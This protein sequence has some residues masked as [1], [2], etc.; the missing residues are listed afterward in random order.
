MNLFAE[1]L[2]DISVE[3]RS[4]EGKCRRRRVMMEKEFCLV[5]GMEDP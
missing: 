3:V 2:A 1:V 5:L 4:L